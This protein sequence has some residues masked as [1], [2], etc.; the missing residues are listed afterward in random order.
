MA[1]N[2]Q[3]D[4]I[5]QAFIMRANRW[6]LH[7]IPCERGNMRRQWTSESAV[8]TDSGRNMGSEQSYITV[9]EKGVHNSTTMD[10]RARFRRTLS[11]QSIGMWHLETSK[12][13]HH[14]TSAK[15]PTRYLARGSCARY[16]INHAVMRKAGHENAGSRQ[17]RRPNNNPLPT[18]R[19]RI[20]RVLCWG[21]VPQWSDH[22]TAR[23]KKTNVS[24]G[25]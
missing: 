14:R 4:N 10:S 23:R 21:A 18:G 5:H 1:Q 20:G 7:A 12:V 9:Q 17:R 13:T 6:N 19:L 15:I 16:Q 8:N 11:M 22:G 2:E 3:E 25:F 24:H